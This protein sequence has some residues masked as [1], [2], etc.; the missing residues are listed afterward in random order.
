[1]ALS[2]SE[3]R[4]CSDGPGGIWGDPEPRGNLQT[5]V[6]VGPEIRLEQPTGQT[7]KLARF[8]RIV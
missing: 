8:W 2:I 3:A 4:E 7:G 6:F 5:L 1:L